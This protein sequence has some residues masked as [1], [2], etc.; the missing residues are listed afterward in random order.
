M[1]GFFTDYTTFSPE[2]LGGGGLTSTPSTTPLRKYVLD[3]VWHFIVE[4]S[5]HNLNLQNQN[6]TLKKQ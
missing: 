4:T 6:F 1:T 3:R 5:K 2:T